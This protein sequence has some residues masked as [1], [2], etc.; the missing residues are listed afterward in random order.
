MSIVRAAASIGITITSKTA[1]RWALRGANG[2]LLET[3]KIGGRRLTSEAAL[4]RFIAATQQQPEGIEHLADKDADRVLAAY[5]L[6]RADSARR[7]VETRA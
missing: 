6:S 5:G 2:V 4:R 3:V 7:A 1:I